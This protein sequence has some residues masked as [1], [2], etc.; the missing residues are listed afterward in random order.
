MGG[1]ISSIEAYDKLIGINPRLEGLTPPQTGM[2]LSD[3]K[4]DDKGNETGE[5]HGE[6]KQIVSGPVIAQK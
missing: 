6:H 3:D 4:W 5:K 1:I 2:T